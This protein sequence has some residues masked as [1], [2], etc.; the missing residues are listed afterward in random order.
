[1]VER[2]GFPPTGHAG[3]ALLHILENYPRDELL[4]TSE[5]EL[6]GIATGILQLQDRQRLRL[7]VRVDPFARFVSCLVYVPR[8]RYNTALRERMQQI[9]EQAVGASE[10]E[11]QALLSDSVARAAAVHPAHARMAFQPISIS[12]TS[13]GVWSRSPASW[14]DRLRDTLLDACGEEHGNRLFAAYGRAFPASY[15]ER[16]DARAAVPDIVTI[17]ALAGSDT[18][19]LAMTLYR[20]LEDPAEIIR[21]K[22]IRRDHPVLLS[23]A[24]PVLENMGL[25][26]LT[27]E[28]SQIRSTDGRLFSVHDFGLQPTVDGP[29]DVD[30]V[31]ESLPGP[32]PRGLDRPAGERR[33]Q[34][35]GA[36][37]RARAHARSSPCAPTAATSCRSARRSAKPISSRPWAPIPA[38]PA[39]WRHCSTPASILRRASR[40]RSCRPGWRSGSSSS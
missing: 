14:P 29:V 23:D 8:D 4:Q 38:L 17:D 30:A 35:A 28:P 24:L 7:F 27:E 20:R 32:V 39:I 19:D 16:I 36:R 18:D 37:G 31:R 2:A 9:L 15:Q 12:P 40:A 10:S 5:D 22:L 11:F 13:S 33:V 21:F 3:K 6:F 34:P 26:V 25:R 1:M